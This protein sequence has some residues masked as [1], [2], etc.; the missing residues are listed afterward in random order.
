MHPATAR[1]ELRSMRTSPLRSLIS[2]RVLL[3][4]LLQVSV[5][6]CGLAA[7]VL[8]WRRCVWK[9]GG[10]AISSCVLLDNLLQ[11][12]AGMRGLGACVLAWQ[13]SAWK[14]GC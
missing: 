11:V 13:H 9:A 6:V 5:G 8:A 2:P 3:D 10:L 7:C 12:G 14:L 4:E 1:R